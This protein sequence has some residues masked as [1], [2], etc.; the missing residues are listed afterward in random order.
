MK[1]HAKRELFIG[2]TVQPIQN[3]ELLASSI[4]VILFANKRSLITMNLTQKTMKSSLIE[5]EKI[6]SAT[7]YDTLE[8]F[9]INT[10]RHLIVVN[11]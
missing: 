7:Y 6:L 9:I 8:V 4:E 1:Q 11:H 2:A 5:D 10:D 3:C